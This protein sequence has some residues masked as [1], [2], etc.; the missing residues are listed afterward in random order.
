[1]TQEL[2]QDAELEQAGAKSRLGLRTALVLALIALLAVTWQW[3]S[4]R[5]H[6]TQIEQVLS[7][8]LAKFDANNQQSLTVSKMADERS[9][10]ASA[11]L[12]VLR[13]QLAE[14]QNQQEALQTL[15]EQL[16]GN[17]EARV[18]TE[19]EQLV[20][21]ANQ[22]LQLASNVKSALLALQ[23]AHS[24]LQSLDSKEAIALSDSL[25]QDITKLQN[26]PLVDV[27]EMSAQLEELARNVDKLTLV[28]DR[29]PK[30][31]KTESKAES[32]N[33]WAKLSQEIWQDLRNIIRL[34]RIDR[35]E[36][37]LLD[38]EQVF[39]LRENIKLRLLTARIALLQ[40]DEATYRA[41]LKTVQYWLHNHFDTR[42]SAT[43]QALSRIGKLT[44]NSI[45]IQ[46]P[47]ISESLN[48][49]SKYKLSLE[50]KSD[51]EPQAA[52]H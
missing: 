6:F 30:T 14:S 37:P 45:A 34:E 46:I 31:K 22:Q 49:V 7:E 20:V 40:H 15:Y 3:V 23:T 8:K 32:A 18:V 43:Q 26:L 44:A 50:E 27:A 16:A 29:H 10:A 21:I 24:R 17:R 5:R 48:L 39:F 11:E 9:V 42:E 19:T 2:P 12:A 13:Q 1:M 25:A 38:P 33:V 47:D 35:P 36:P 52:R 41:D 4:T 28:S 51:T